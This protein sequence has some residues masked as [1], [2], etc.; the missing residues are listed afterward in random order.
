MGLFDGPKAGWDSFVNNEWKSFTDA[1]NTSISDSAKPIWDRESTK[2]I[3]GEDGADK[4]QDTL[5]PARWVENAVD[6]TVP[7]PLRD[8][9]K[10]AIPVAAI[11]GAA[12]LALLILKMKF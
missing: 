9:T 11:G 10:K 6:E 5:N 2:K 1:L 3:L 4:L 12:L 7:E 8:V